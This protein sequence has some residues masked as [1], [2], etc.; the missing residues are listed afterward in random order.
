MVLK[1]SEF[2]RVEKLLTLLIDLHVE[3]RRCRQFPRLSSWVSFPLCVGHLI[4]FVFGA[5]FVIICSYHLVNSV[6]FTHEVVKII[7]GIMFGSDNGSESIL[8]VAFF[9][10]FL[11]L[12]LISVFLIPHEGVVLHHSLN[13]RFVDDQILL[14]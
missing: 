10:N 7:I 14:T 3:D 1:H 2:M 4:D 11:T 5:L 13:T 6:L 9:F 12:P 8:T